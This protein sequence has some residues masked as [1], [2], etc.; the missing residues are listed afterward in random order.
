MN[1]RRLIEQELA[2]TF[3]ADIRQR[4][5]AALRAGRGTPEWSGALAIIGIRSFGRDLEPPAGWERGV[6]AGIAADKARR[7]ERGRAVGAFALWA[8]ISIGAAIGLL[9]A[10]AVGL[11]VWRWL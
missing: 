5:T 8:V 7:E 10:W 6:E 11:T 1:D 4:L 2:S 9:L 3:D